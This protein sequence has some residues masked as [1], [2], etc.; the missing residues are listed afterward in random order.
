MGRNSANFCTHRPADG[1]IHCRRHRARGCGGCLGNG[2]AVGGG[3][4]Q[5]W[6]VKWGSTWPKHKTSQRFQ[7]TRKIN[8]TTY[9]M[10]RLDKSFEG[11]CVV[12][13][14]QVSVLKQDNCKCDSIF[15]EQDIIR[16]QDNSMPAN[17]IS[18]Y[19][20]LP[21]AHCVQNRWMHD[22]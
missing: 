7:N 21:S 20:F 1:S 6:L 11:R 12:K 4:R 8:A 19:T 2:T 9:Q 3:R 16:N 5:L 14:E 15:F 22:I 18:S 17:P 13:Q 10:T